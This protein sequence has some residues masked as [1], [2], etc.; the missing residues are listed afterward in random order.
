MLS[1]S[2]ILWLPLLAGSLILSACMPE[3]SANA[4]AG[5]SV[6]VTNLSNNQPLS[7]PALIVHSDEYH[8][9]MIGSPASDGLEQLAE[10]GDSSLW[11]TEA[12]ADEAVIEVVAGS[13]LVL[14]GQTAEFEFKLKRRDAQ[15]LSLATMLVNTNDAF[16]GI[17]AASLA[18][19]QK[20]SVQTYY[21]KVYD[22]GTEEN[23]ETAASIPG[24]AGGG[25][26]YNSTRESADQV[27]MHGGVVTMDDGL[28]TSI[29][30]ESHRFDN[31]V[32]KVVIT[33]M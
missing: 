22:A 12:L 18:D 24:P 9:W 14:P 4:K 30:D 29:L 20:G 26:G 1:K 3:D 16:T 8:A 17:N 5:F 27:T 10:G 25:E 23:T 33:R 7:P 28:A 6:A 15:G 2:K 31:P 11:Q 19:M 32:A 21:L 13:D